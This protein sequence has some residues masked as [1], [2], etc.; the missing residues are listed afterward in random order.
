M[1]RILKRGISI[2]KDL[3]KPLTKV[4]KLKAINQAEVQIKL[5]KDYLKEVEENIKSLSKDD[6]EMMEILK[7]VEKETRSE[8]K[9]FDE[10]IINIKMGEQPFTL[11]MK[12]KGGKK[13]K[14]KKVKRKKNKR[15]TRKR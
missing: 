6:K 7:D 10:E 2:I 8:I 9:R 3:K 1:S 15:K 4:E 12:K 5:N 11:S 13:R 14:T